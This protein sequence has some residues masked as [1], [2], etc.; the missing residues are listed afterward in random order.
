MAVITAADVVVNLPSLLRYNPPGQPNRS[1]PTITFGAA[2]GNNQYPTNG[3]PLPSIGAWG[4]HKSLLRMIIQEPPDGYVYKY[5]PVNNTIRI[6]EVGAASANITGLTATFT[7][8][9][10]NHAHDLLLLANIA[11]FAVGA[12]A[13]MLGSNDTANLTIHGSAANGGVQPSANI[14]PAG[15]VAMGGNATLAAG[16]LVEMATNTV[17]NLPITLYLECVGE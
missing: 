14:T 17:I 8:T 6:F 5:D 10:A 7:G 3:V 13:T 12:N 1:F 2:S 4:F 16:P 11:N 9:P 15:T